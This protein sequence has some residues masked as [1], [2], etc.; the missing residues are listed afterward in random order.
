[1]LQLPDAGLNR[2][3][4]GFGRTMI[5][6]LPLINKALLALGTFIEHIGKISYPARSE[7]LRI[8]AA[9]TEN[10]SGCFSGVQPII[11]T[12]S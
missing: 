12:A 10:T 6:I 4:T 7:H 5:I 11:K 1:M 8:N 9:V 3:I 2:F